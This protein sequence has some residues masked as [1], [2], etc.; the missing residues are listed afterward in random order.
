MTNEQRMSC[1]SDMSLFTDRM[2]YISDVALSSMW[3]DLESKWETLDVEK[4]TDDI[5]ELEERADMLGKLWDAYHRDVKGI[6]EEAGLTQRDLAERFFIPRRTV[7]DWCRG[8]RTPP[9]YVRLMMQELL[10][11]I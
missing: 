6:C 7:E 8:V 2:A 4:S 3:D 11:L 9:D 1:L 10:G 5:T